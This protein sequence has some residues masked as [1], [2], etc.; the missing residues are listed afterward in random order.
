M[1]VNLFFCGDSNTYGEELQGI[2]DNHQKRIDQRYSSLVSKKLGKTHENISQS[3]ACNDWIVKTVVEWFE[4]GNKCDTA[5]IQFSAATRW[6]WYDENGQY[7]NMSNVNTTDCL[8]TDNMKYAHSTYYKSIW[9][10]KLELDNYWKNMFFLKNYLR[11]KC[12]VIWMTLQR[13]PRGTKEDHNSNDWQNLCADIEIGEQKWIVDGNKCQKY[14]KIGF[15]GTHPN[16]VGHMNIA[17]YIIKR[18]S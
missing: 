13:I 8:T 2:E 15:T 18:L 10:E 9:S 12:N 1:N 17:N 14:D 11:G 5:I 6:G 7:Q 16:E 4:L 3:G